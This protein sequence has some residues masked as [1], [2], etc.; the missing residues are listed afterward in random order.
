VVIAFDFKYV[1]EMRARASLSHSFNGFNKQ[2]VALP[3]KIICRYV[4]LNLDGGFKVFIL[5]E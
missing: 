4:L 3:T 2:R 1:G 5:T